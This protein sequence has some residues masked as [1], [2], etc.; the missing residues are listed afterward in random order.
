VDG[1]APVKGKCNWWREK[2]DEEDRF[3]TRLKRERHRVH[4][5]CFVEGRGWEYVVEDLPEDCPESRRCR[6]YIKNL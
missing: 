6:Y 2:L 3:D 1:F 5:S 4:C